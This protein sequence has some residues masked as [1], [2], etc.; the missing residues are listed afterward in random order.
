MT[1]RL[2][3]PL[4]LVVLAIGAAA[5]GGDDE[6][7]GSTTGTTAELSGRVQADGSST[8]APF[9]TQAA[10]RFQQRQSGVRVTVGVSGTGGG[11]ERFCAGETDISDASRPIAEDEQQACQA[12]GIEFVEFQVANDAITLITSKDA[13]FLTCLT[14]DQLK[15]IWGP[16]SKIDSWSEVDPQFPDTELQLFGPGTDSGTFDFFTDEING[17]EGVS[18]SDYTASEDDNVIVRGVSGSEG[19]LGYLGFSYYEENAATLKA[20]EVNGGN[21]CVAPSVE[22]TQDRSYRPLSRPLFVYVKTSAFARPEVKEFVRFMLANAPAIAEGA[23][24]I[25]LTERQVARAERQFR[26]AAA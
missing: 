7:G 9:T 1:S 17:E 26:R 5:C 2:M 22:S 12:E 20:L 4:A 19:G 15:K 18:R 6:E 14:T 11:F 23:K 25:P 24:L 3:L 21:G 8:V 16:G 13:D 10:E